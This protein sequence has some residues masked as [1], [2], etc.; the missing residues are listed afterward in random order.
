ML[1]IYTHILP[2]RRGTETVPEF[3]S[4]GL[5]EVIFS[6]KP[7]EH[8]FYIRTQKRSPDL[9]HRMPYVEPH[10]QPQLL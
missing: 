10:C 3:M 5:H 4:Y 9:N 6:G 1:T 2:L 7:E 8:G